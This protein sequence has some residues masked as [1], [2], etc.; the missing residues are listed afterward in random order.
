MDSDAKNSELNVAAANP[1]SITAI[2]TIESANDTID[3]PTSRSTTPRAGVKDGEAPEQSKSGTSSGASL[4]LVAKY[5]LPPPLLSSTEFDNDNIIPIVF[6]PV[7]A[8]S[9]DSQEDNVSEIDSNVQEHSEKSDQGSIVIELDDEGNDES[10]TNGHTIE[11]VGREV[12]STAPTVNNINNH[13]LGDNKHPSNKVDISGTEVPVSVIN[14]P[15]TPSSTINLTE[16]LDEQLQEDQEEAVASYTSP[17]FEWARILQKRLGKNLS[18]AQLLARSNSMLASPSILAQ[19]LTQVIPSLQVK[20]NSP[21]SPGSTIKYQ[22]AEE[23]FDRPASIEPSYLPYNP[24]EH[25]SRDDPFPSSMLASG[26]QAQLL[27]FAPLNPDQLYGKNPST[28]QTTVP[29]ANDNSSQLKVPRTQHQPTVSPVQ[30]Q[31]PSQQPSAQQPGLNAAHAIP[32]QKNSPISIP[33]SMATATPTPASKN[34]PLPAI[35]GG[36]LHQSP[37]M[38]RD[39]NT[40]SKNVR[41]S[42]GLHTQDDRLVAIT[43]KTL[44]AQNSSSALVGKD[45][46]GAASSNNPIAPIQ[47]T[48]LTK[49]KPI[50]KAHSLPAPAKE[51]SVSAQA[52]VIDPP[53]DTNH[54]QEAL[55]TT[56]TAAAITTQEESRLEPP[57]ISAVAAESTSSQWVLEALS[58]FSDIN[59]DANLPASAIVAT[60][61]SSAS[62]PIEPSG[63]VPMVIPPISVRSRSNLSANESSPEKAKYIPS[64]FESVKVNVEHHQSSL[65]T[66]QKQSGLAMVDHANMPVSAPLSSPSVAPIAPQQSLYSAPLQDSNAPIDQRMSPVKYGH[67][68]QNAASISDIT[69]TSATG[70]PPT[71]ELGAGY[72]IPWLPQSKPI[73]PPRDNI[74][75]IDVPALTGKQL[76]PLEPREAP[77]NSQDPCFQFKHLGEA[78]RHWG[79]TMPEGNAFANLDGKGIECGSWDWAFTLGKAEM[80]AKAINDKTQ[81]RAGS[82]VALV[83]RISEILEFVAAF[84]GAMLAG[85]VP[86][87]VNQIQEF[88]EMV[89][90]MT[91][92]KVELALTTQFNHQALQK[93]MRKGSLWPSG[94]TWW[95]TDI[96]ETWAPKNNQ[97]E[98]LPLPDNE[99]AYIEYTKSAS[100]ELKGVAVS[101]LNL[102]T[103]CRSLYSSFLWRPALFRDKHNHLQPDP[104]LA[105]NPAVAHSMDGKKNPDKPALSGTV[106]SWLEPR[107]Q[108]GLVLGCIMGVFCGNFTVFMETGI[109]AVSGLW[110]HS[111]AAYRANISFADYHGIQRLLKNYRVNPQATTTPSRP[112]L[113]FLHTIYVDAQCNNV[114]LNR[115]FM[116]EFLYPLGMIQRFSI[117]MEGLAE[118]EAASKKC[119][120]ELGVIPFLSLPDHGGMIVA[121]RDPLIHPK[122][123]ENIELRRPHRPSV[124]PKPRRPSLNQPEELGEQNV[125]SP[126]TDG[127]SMS[128]PVSSLTSG[129]YLLHRASLRANRIVVLA[130][131]KEAFDRRNDEGAILV[132]AFGYP[133]VQ[134]SVL[135]V[136]PETLALSLPDTVGEI[137]VSYPGQPMTFW[138]LPEHSQEIFQAK[139]Y[140]IPEETMVT[141]IYQAEGS[142]KMLRT[143]LLGTVI[144]GRVVVFGSY[145]DRLQQDLADPMKSIGFQYEYHHFSDLSQT[146]FTRVGGISDISIFECQVNKD[147]LPVICIEISKE[148]RANGQPINSVAQQVAINARYILQEVNG[149]RSYCVAVWDQNTL[150]RMFK[151]GRRVID[152]AL[153]KMMFEMGRIYKLLYFATFT[154]DVVFN[155]P[156]GDDPVNECTVK[157]QR[158]Q[159]VAMRFVQYTSNIASSDAVDEKTNVFMAKFHNITDILMWR[160]IIQPEDIAFVELDSRGREQR[161]ISFKKF[162][163]RVTGYAMYLEKKCGLKAGDHVI[164]WFSQ[165]L[166]YVVTLHAC[167]VL[168]L[169][170]IPLQLPDGAY[171]NAHSTTVPALGLGINPSLNIGI[172]APS[173]FA[174]ATSNRV[175]EEKKSAIIKALFCILDEVKVKAI[176]GNMATDDFLKQKSTGTALRTRRAAFSASYMQ[177]SEAFSSAEIILP[178]FL[179]VTKAPKNKQTLGA[180]SGYAPRKEWFAA[181]YAAV[182]LID[183]DLRAGSVAAKKLLRLNH[184]TLNCLCRNQKLQFKARS[185][186][187]NIACMN[188]FNGLGFIRGC[189]SGIYNGGPTILL[190]PIDIYTNPTNWLETIARYK[191]QDV[192]LS[193]QLL[194]QLLQKLDVIAPHSTASLETVK[195]FVICGHGRIQRKALGLN[196]LHALKLDPLSIDLVYSHPLNLM[197]TS[198]SDRIAGPVRIHVSSKQLRYGIITPTTEGDDPTGIWL[199]DA[200]TPT[201]CTSIAI[202]H[203]ETMEV[204]SSNQVGE[205]WVCSDSST[206][207]FHL[208]AGY[209]PNAMQPQAFGA[210][211]TGYDNRVRYVRTGDIGFLWNSQQQQVVN[212]GQ[213]NPGQSA[214]GLFQLFV[215]GSIDEAFQVHGLLHF[216]AD[217][218]ATIESSHANVAAQ[219]CIVFKTPQGKSIC[220]VKVRKQEPELLVSMYIP[221]MHAVL[222]QHQFLP[223]TIILVGDNVSTARRASDGLKPRDS[224]AKLY[225][226]DRLPLLHLHYCHGKP[227]APVKSNLLP[228]TGE[229]PPNSRGSDRSISQQSNNQSTSIP[230]SQSNFQQ[231]QSSAPG[232]RIIPGIG[233]A[234]LSTV[235]SGTAP[236]H[237]Y[238]AGYSGSN[239]PSPVEPHG[240]GRNRN[241]MFSSPLLVA[242]IPMPP[243]TINP[244][245]QSPMLNS[246]VGSY[247]PQTQY[248]Q[249]SYGAIP[250]SA[251]SSISA[252]APVL[253]HHQPPNVSMGYHNNMT[254]AT[255]YGRPLSQQGFVSNQPYTGGPN[256]GPSSGSSASITNSQ[257]ATS[258][259]AVI[260]GQVR[261]TSSDR[262]R[263]LQHQHSYLHQQPSAGGQRATHPRQIRGQESRSSSSEE[264]RME[265]KAGSGG[266]YQ[267][268]MKGV[269]AKWTEIRKLT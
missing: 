145:W 130:T 65:S 157:R 210:C 143:G 205:I 187:A 56:P 42:V 76:L 75:S 127:S 135:V 142:D 264:L 37:L 22:T 26:S 15:S 27:L 126:T 242:N 179:N 59:F 38:S 108:S 182:Y 178:T 136:D 226:T 224:I 257:A 24:D 111:V 46:H 239:N 252:A 155:I 161:T 62:H 5:P 96:L 137:W 234:P 261:G 171:L 71:F 88:S 250:V 61:L 217:I 33:H 124:L 77:V 258:G 147:Y 176:L 119:R 18:D 263:G 51:P 72:Q 139:P 6:P 238:G 39:T 235:R 14:A 194:E 162:N 102:M 267:S 192:V 54:D 221:L 169:I 100:G 156:R 229:S 13:N 134:S 207:G 174:S 21:L 159:G 32:N 203:P 244:L 89:Y 170:P 222:E 260:T 23:L 74:N 101:H 87:L 2:T 236:S 60:T 196:R 146:L 245:I 40:G 19:S 104:N 114:R 8:N 243:G 185:G 151:S 201:V 36:E 1:L 117:S 116:D 197:V 70:I 10:Q 153:C 123:A 191:A 99:L 255:E 53:T 9:D 34:Q 29:P 7:N 177:T 206:N 231:Q 144:E 106:M 73:L 47:Y 128:N 138:G 95:Q 121:L 4:H 246:N 212:Q 164:L 188:V 20:E 131:G 52:S 81:L 83:F 25:T 90:I 204:C 249:S 181:S 85:M 105:L 166:D 12:V 266:G 132:G 214:V 269:N 141:Q 223:D 43:H 253:P 66:E 209:Q 213:W 208:P 92:A 78:L 64:P 57:V 113:R 91:S 31:Q 240:G 227:L 163:Q 216:A 218:E 120:S 67:G 220:V 175:N 48:P 133:L 172:N 98:R 158:R 86:V 189:L 228:L 41:H 241:S 150:P 198:Q 3:K 180:L 16:H 45:Q 232:M 193:H 256:N 58:G 183:P 50:K 109:T 44:N 165:D 129:E 237:M 215:L 68:V 219:G 211:I 149:L 118:H 103:Q 28:A 248:Q 173:H 122:G 200:G 154:D 225:I 184:E 254:T 11:A 17:N 140:V 112:D 93:D 79:Q 199:E 160:S 190:Q 233:P 268:F 55:S 195:N 168:G 49:Y 259:S 262:S 202:V 69:P 97:Q 167:W 148:S 35:S 265:G 30:L 107:Q 110:A 251:S 82:R 230:Q 63:K 94:V 115:E 152:H 80:V 125:K 186:Q 247:V 84:Y